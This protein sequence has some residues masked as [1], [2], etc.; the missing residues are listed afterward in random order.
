MTPR[1]VLKR[2]P[3]LLG[4]K[5]REA[6]SLFMSPLSPTAQGLGSMQDVAAAEPRT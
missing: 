2:S 3:A 6:K 1:V 4:G 5:L